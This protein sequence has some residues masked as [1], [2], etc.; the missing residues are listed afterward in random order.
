MH[1]MYLMQIIQRAVHKQH[2][3][4]IG[5]IHIITEIC[6]GKECHLPGRVGPSVGRSTADRA[7]RSS[8]PILA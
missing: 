5:S 2:H 6:S 8:N 3:S 4:L 1:V 7:V